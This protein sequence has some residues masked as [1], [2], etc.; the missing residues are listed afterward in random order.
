M[1]VFAYTIDV[2]KDAEVVELFANV[3]RDAGVPDVLVN[4]AG[5]A[6]SGY[7]PFAQSDPLGWWSVWVGSLKRG[8]RVVRTLR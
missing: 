8:R 2:S 7:V 4:N 5:V 6:E 1:K 3:K